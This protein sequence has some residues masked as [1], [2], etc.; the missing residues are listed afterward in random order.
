MSDESG[1]FEIYVRPF[2]VNAAG[3]AIE[4]GGKWLISTG[5][6]RSPKWNSNGREL[7]YQ[8]SDRKMMAVEI[9][10]SPA[11]RAGDSRPIGLVAPGTDWDSTPDGKRFLIIAANRGKQEPY[12]VVLNWQA[13]L[14]Q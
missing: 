12:T 2:S 13:G 4:P 3:T 6:G 9:T 7:Y 10:T 8:A 5:G 11:F 14:K 1:K